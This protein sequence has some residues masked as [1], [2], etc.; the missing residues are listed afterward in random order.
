VN[1]DKWA[2]FYLR[3]NPWNETILISGRDVWQKIINNAR[4]WWSCDSLEEAESCLLEATFL[5]DC[6]RSGKPA[7]PAF[8]L[9]PNNN[10]Y[11]LKQFFIDNGMTL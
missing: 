2:T 5:C 10:P 11:S 6:T 3:A 1:N 7:D 9:H 4:T 8:T